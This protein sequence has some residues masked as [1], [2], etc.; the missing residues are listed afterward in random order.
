MLLDTGATTVT[1]P[2]HMAE[3][4]KLKPLGSHWAK[5]AAGNIQ[6]F[7]TRI[8]TL[9]IGRITLHHIEATINPH[10]QSSYILLGMSALKHLNWQQSGNQLKL[11]YTR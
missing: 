11:Q 1:V 2:Q 10:D 9:S 6:V 5:T 4:F 8:D 3:T 7:S